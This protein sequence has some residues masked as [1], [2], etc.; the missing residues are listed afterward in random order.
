MPAAPWRPSRTRRRL[1]GCSST[2]CWIRRTPAVTR[3]T[4]ESL[5]RR[6]DRSGLT[7][8]ASALAAADP[9]HSDWIH[10]AVNDVFGVFS[11]D[12]DHAIRVCEEILQDSDDRLARGA[13]QLRG[14]LV[15][16]DPALHP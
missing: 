4:A 13:E 12:R 16:I 8:V 3:V 2:S 6:K 7:I 10:T 5:L 14:I 9:N 11:I 1:S 15:E